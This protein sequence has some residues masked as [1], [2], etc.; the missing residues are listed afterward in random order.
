[1]FFDSHSVSASRQEAT[2]V[3]RRLLGPAP[4]QHEHVCIEGRAESEKGNRGKR[5]EPLAWIG[6]KNAKTTTDKAKSHDLHQPHDDRA[7][8]ARLGCK[9]VFLPQPFV[10]WLDATQ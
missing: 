4:P 1:M 6:N 7:L 9:A 5:H 2:L 10:R 8:R 3:P